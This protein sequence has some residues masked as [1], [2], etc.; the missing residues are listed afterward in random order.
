VP[1]LAGLFFCTPPRRR[2]PVARILQ[3]DPIRSFFVPPYRRTVVR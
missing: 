3:D 2:P 1:T